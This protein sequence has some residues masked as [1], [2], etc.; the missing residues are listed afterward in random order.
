MKYR[1]RTEI[2][3]DILQAANSDGNG[4]VKTKITYNAFL[5]YHQVKE[6]LTILI[7]NDLLQYD[8]DTRRFRITEKGLGFL[9]LCEQM[10]D[11]VEKEEEQ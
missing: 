2:I 7:D 11:L 4:V 10:A 8:L 6:Y 1:S 9:Q 3:C 5:S